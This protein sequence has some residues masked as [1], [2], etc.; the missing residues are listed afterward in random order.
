MSTGLAV[1]TV[2]AA[3]GLGAVLQADPAVLDG[4]RLIGT[5][6]LISLAVSSWRTSRAPQEPPTTV[7]QRSLRKVYA[8]ATLTDM[9]NPQVVLSTS[10]LYPSS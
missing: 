4:A 9:A 5:L 10:P 1:H 7:P 8:M 6:L 3:V 2:A